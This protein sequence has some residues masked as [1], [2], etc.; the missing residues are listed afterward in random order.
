MAKL[1]SFVM[2]LG[3]LLRWRR[4]EQL[5]DKLSITFG[6]GFSDAVFDVFRID[7][8]S[9]WK[10]IDGLQKSIS[11]DQKSINIDEILSFSIVVDYNERIN[12]Q[13][14]VKFY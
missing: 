11:N 1:T 8:F 6:I 12:F 2:I 4:Q 14:T 10:F 3:I 9:E 7:R 5:I 13:N